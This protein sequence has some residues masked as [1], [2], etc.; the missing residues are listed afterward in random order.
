MPHK[1]LETCLPELAD[2]IRPDAERLGAVK[3]IVEDRL[4]LHHHA[5]A[6]AALITGIQALLVQASSAAMM[7]AVVGGHSFDIAHA[8]SAYAPGAQG[9]V[10]VRRDQM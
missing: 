7:A 1:T 10:Y 8:F 2:L 3:K 6:P 9:K 5:T 4:P